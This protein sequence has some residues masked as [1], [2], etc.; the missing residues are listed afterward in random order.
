MQGP[1]NLGP[2]PVA[3]GDH[4]PGPGPA[5]PANSVAVVVPAVQLQPTAPLP[6]PVVPVVPQPVV[7][8]VLVLPPETT[9][10]AIVHALQTPD[11]GT[12]P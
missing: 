6:Q 4:V 10:T 5:G 9:A 3:G 1:Q 12:V 7:P 11:V 2:D 8:V